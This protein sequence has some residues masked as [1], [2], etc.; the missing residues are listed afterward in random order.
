M[1]RNAKRKEKE[2]RMGHGDKFSSLR[3]EEWMAWGEAVLTSL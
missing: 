3:I 1:R 2:I